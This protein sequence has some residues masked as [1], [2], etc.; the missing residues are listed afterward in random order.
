MNKRRVWF[1]AQVLFLLAVA[2]NV[3]ALLLTTR[4]VSSGLWELDPFRAFELAHP[5]LLVPLSLAAYASLYFVVRLSRKN[6]PLLPFFLS[7]FLFV[8]FLVDFSHDLLV[9]VEVNLL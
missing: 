7:L 6:H 8:S 5:F 1:L 3:L 4:A 2:F 9:L